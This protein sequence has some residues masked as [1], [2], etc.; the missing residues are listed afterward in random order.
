MLAASGCLATPDSAP[1]GVDATTGDPDPI[2]RQIDRDST[3]ATPIPDDDASGVS[4][5]IAVDGECAVKELEVDI[6]IRHPW[7]SDLQ[8]TLHEPGGGQARLH[9][10]EGNDPQDD[11]VGTYPVTLSPVDSLVAL[12]GLPA[13]G[14][15]VMQVADV[16][17]DD[18]GTF[19][20]W[21]LHIQCR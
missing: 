14:S 4:D 10:H 7:R 21:A 18:V 6:D 9:V 12:V 17:V 20:S 1:A 2:G 11:L 5:S 15:W 16:S 13:A 19:Q 8:V 3:P